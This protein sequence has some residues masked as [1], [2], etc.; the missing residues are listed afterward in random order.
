M[1]ADPRQIIDSASIEPMLPALGIWAP[2]GFITIYASG[3]ILRAPSALLGL[4]IAVS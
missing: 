4:T 1:A 3:T 2:I